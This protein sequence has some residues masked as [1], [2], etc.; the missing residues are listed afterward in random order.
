MHRPLHSHS[1]RSLMSVL[2]WTIRAL[3][4]DA[5]GSVT[6]SIGRYQSRSS[7]A[8]FCVRSALQLRCSNVTRSHHIAECDVASAYQW[9]DVHRGF[10]VTQAGGCT[11]NARGAVRPTRQGAGSRP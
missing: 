4:L 9:R 10:F 5:L 3:Q 1:R 7:R 11:D 8:T 2:P 6:M